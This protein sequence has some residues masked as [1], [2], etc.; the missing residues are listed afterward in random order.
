[1]FMNLTH[2]P[3]SFGPAM[4]EIAT[5][6]GMLVRRVRARRSARITLRAADYDRAA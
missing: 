3:V 4:R 5:E 6:I 1:M 2:E